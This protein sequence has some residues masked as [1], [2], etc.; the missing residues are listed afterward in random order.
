VEPLRAPHEEDDHHDDEHDDEHTDDRHDA[1]APVPYI[2]S[3]NVVPFVD[4]M[5][6]DSTLGEEAQ[7]SVLEAECSQDDSSNTA[8]LG[9]S[10]SSAR[11]HDWGDVS[12][13]TGPTHIFQ[14][15]EDCQGPEQRS[16]VNLLHG[17]HSSRTSASEVLLRG[18]VARGEECRKASRDDGDDKDGP[19]LEPDVDRSTG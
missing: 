5:V 1:T 8:A 2:G 17:S 4:G 7:L 16:K 13:R 3:N 15:L 9:A 12:I 10:R 19:N 11:V 14:T 18:R 6:P